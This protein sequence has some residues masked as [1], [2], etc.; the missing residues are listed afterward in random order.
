MS[1]FAAKNPSLTGFWFAAF[2]YCAAL[3]GCKS[4]STLNKNDLSVYRRT[5][6]QA[7][8]EIVKTEKFLV[9]VG[10]VVSIEGLK[11]E[12]GASTLTARHKLILQQVFNSL[13]E[14][15]ENTPGDTNVTRVGEFKKMKFEIRGFPDPSRNREDRDPSALAEERAKA[16]LSFL[17][18]LGTPPWRLK[19]TVFLPSHSGPTSVDANKFGAVD[20]VR[21]Q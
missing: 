13:E 11:F 9:P 5:N 7:G 14:I 8:H 21:T 1:Y 17:T 15:T 18:Y 3:T 4:P 19:A 10:S 16:V 2:L 6:D 20:F 12:P